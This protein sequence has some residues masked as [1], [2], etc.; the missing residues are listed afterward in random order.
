MSWGRRVGGRG[1]RVEPAQP[2]DATNG[3]AELVKKMVLIFAPRR[4]FF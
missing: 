1:V 3:E 2:A 4:L